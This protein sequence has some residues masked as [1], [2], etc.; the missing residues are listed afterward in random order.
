MHALLIGDSITEAFNVSE[1]LP[2]FNIDNRGVSGNSTIETYEI[3]NEEWFEKQPETIFIC[4]GTNDLARE[5]T[6]EEIVSNILKIKD[7]LKS[8]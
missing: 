5:R 2:E 3:I 1:L 7:K 6:N 4:I 8:T